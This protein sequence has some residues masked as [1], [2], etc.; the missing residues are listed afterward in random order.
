MSN[1]QSTRF[2]TGAAT[3]QKNPPGRAGCNGGARPHLVW[4]RRYHCRRTLRARVLVGIIP[5]LSP[6]PSCTHADT[7][8]MY[9]M[10]PPSTRNRWLSGMGWSGTERSSPGNPRKR[11]T[12]PYTSSTR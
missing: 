10:R 5:P 11:S 9:R 7:V 8:W 3:L 1:N 6:H 12:T 2:G 4:P